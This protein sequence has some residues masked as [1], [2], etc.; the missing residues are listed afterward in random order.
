MIQRF[1]T[2]RKLGNPV[3]SLWDVFGEGAEAPGAVVEVLGAEVDV[4]V[5]ALEL[6]G[7][8]PC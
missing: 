5:A 2:G 1:G 7:G 4:P 3:T 8:N 6:S